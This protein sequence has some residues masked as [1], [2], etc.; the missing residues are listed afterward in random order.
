MFDPE[1]L[2]RYG[3]LI[4]PVLAVFCQTGLFFFVFLFQVEDCYLR[5]AYLWLQGIYQGIY[6]WSA[7][8]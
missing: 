5:Q 8:C 7:V 6:S 4:L 2:I 3:G 1:S